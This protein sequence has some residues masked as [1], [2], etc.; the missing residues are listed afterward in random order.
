MQGPSVTQGDIR[1]RPG[2]GLSGKPFK[3]PAC[4]VDMSPRFRDLG[5]SLQKRLQMSDPILT[6]SSLEEEEGKPVVCAGGGGVKVENPP[7]RPDGLVNHADMGIGNRHLLQNVR[8]VGS[9]PEGEAKRCQRLMVPFLPEEFHTF[10]VVVGITRGVV[11]S[12]GD[13]IPPPGHT[14][15]LRW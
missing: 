7:V 15:I 3:R 11:I 6:A 4:V 13:Q 1:L 12:A 14:A 10:L 9:I 8:V 2:S 5:G